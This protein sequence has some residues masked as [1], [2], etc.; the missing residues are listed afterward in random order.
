MK[1]FITNEVNKMRQVYAITPERIISDFRKEKREMNGYK[2][3]QILE[4]LQNAD[5]ASEN[6]E[7][8]HVYIDL[9]SNLYPSQIMESILLKRELNR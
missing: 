4:L 7:K 9:S 3:R 5:D 6:A 8:K 2:G 1:Q